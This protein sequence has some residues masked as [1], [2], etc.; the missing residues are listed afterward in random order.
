MDALFSWGQYD[1]MRSA[2]FAVLLIMP[3]FALL[4]TMVVIDHHNGYT[5]TYAS[6]EPE[7]KVLAGDEVSAGTV[8]GTVGNTS[9]SEAGLGAHLHFAVAKDGEPVDPAGFLE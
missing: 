6:L 9:L 7:T 5:T 2:L 3:L 8:I 1:F 4:G